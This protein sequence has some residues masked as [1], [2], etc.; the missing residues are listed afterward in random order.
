MDEQ[1][2]RLGSRIKHLR[3]ARKVTLRE[4]GAEL[5]VAAN[6]VNRWE[7]GESSPTKKNLIALSDLFLVD[8]S[9][10][11]F[12]KTDSNTRRNEDILI[13]KIRLLNDEQHVAVEA[14]INLLIEFALTLVIFGSL[15]IVSKYSVTIVQSKICSFSGLFSASNLS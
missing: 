6:T 2:N 9:W 8:P 11:M 12:G 1:E 3:K 7:R 14:L 4:V 5:G 13:R 15:P 10:L